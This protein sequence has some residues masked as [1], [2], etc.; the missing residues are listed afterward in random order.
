MKEL[1]HTNYRGYTLGDWLIVFI[2]LVVG[3][4]VSDKFPSQWHIGNIPAGVLAS[5]TIFCVALVFVAGP[6]LPRN[7]NVR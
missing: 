4:S 2:S 5:L 1:W 7:T 3:F 6:K